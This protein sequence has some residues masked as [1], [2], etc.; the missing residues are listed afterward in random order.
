[1]TNTQLRCGGAATVSV[2]ILVIFI[3]GFPRW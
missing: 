2:R 3:A 1:L